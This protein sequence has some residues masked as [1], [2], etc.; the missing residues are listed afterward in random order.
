M[1]LYF[2]D[3]D[4]NVV[5]FTDSFS[6]LVWS[7]RFFD[8]GRFTVHFP[9]ELFSRLADAVYVRSSPSDDGKIKCGRIEHI[10]AE[11]GGKCKLEGHLLECLLGD[12]I[13]SGSGVYSGTVT[14]A[15]CEAV[16]DNLRSCE[17]IIADDQPAIS[18]TVSLSYDHDS[19]TD[20]LYSTL[21]PY[22]ASF[23]VTLDGE[24]NKPV[25]RIVVGENRT[26][27]SGSGGAAVFSSSFGNIVSLEYERDSTDMKNYAYVKGEDGTI[28][29]VDEST[30]YSRREI[31]IK[32]DDIRR[33]DF[34]T[35]A[36]YRTAL[37]V[38]GH[39]ALADRTDGNRVEAECD[40]DA[41]PKYGRDYFLGDLCDVCAPEYGLSFALR[42]TEADTVTENGTTTV[43]PSFGDEIKSIKKLLGGR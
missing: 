12:R 38:R 21:K 18:D 33:E 35:E 24:T 25:F 19:L 36:D 41:L 42:L 39:E 43:F 15:V 13:M 7:E 31:H 26:T 17:V 29:H 37:S 32:A 2:L 1:E 27:D 23:R 3:K 6:S 30:P 9:R 20:W 10:S 16:S 28:V 11:S 34:S 5:D 4:F 40:P 22:G 8:I 14:E